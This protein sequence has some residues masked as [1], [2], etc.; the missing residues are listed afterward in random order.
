MNFKK[1]LLMEMPMQSSNG[2]ALVDN[3][4]MLVIFKPDINFK[5]SLRKLNWDEAVA[6]N[7]ILGVMG[8]RDN[9]V[10][11]SLE[12]GEIW[13][14]HGYGPL[15]YHIALNKAKDY[16]LMPTRVTHH[17]S[18]EAKSVWKNFYSGIAKDT[19]TPV[20]TDA[21]NHEEDYLNNKYVINKNLPYVRSMIQRGKIFFFGDNKYNE[22]FDMF[23]ELSVFLLKEELNKIYPTDG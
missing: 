17:L 12:V 4:D 3:N 10:Y 8:I 15:L 21:E 9:T 5:R 22:Q 16:G 13:A 1:Y 20:K 19:V 6:T 18:P 11:N 23:L 7:T 14:K 2:L